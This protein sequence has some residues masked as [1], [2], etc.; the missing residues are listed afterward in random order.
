MTN[1][2]F[3]QGHDSSHPP[4]ITNPGMQITEKVREE[5]KLWLFIDKD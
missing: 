2:A 1:V 3:G 4:A 5:A